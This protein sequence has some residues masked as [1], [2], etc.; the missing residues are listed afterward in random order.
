MKQFCHLHFHSRCCLKH[1]VQG[2][3]LPRDDLH[4]RLMAALKARKESTF[5]WYSRDYMWHLAEK[6]GVA[7]LNSLDNGTYVDLLNQASFYYSVHADV[8]ARLALEKFRGPQSIDDRASVRENYLGNLS[9]F[10]FYDR[11]MM[12]RILGEAPFFY[13][14]G[15]RGGAHGACFHGCLAVSACKN[16]ADAVFPGVLPDSALPWPAVVCAS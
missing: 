2:S 3:I 5:V 14:V 16:A 13:F 1:G 15:S 7:G 12:D 9:K 11:K 10:Q 6:R 4:V 8:R